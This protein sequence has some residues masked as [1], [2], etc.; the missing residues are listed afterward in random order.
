MSE[1][2]KA[3]YQEIAPEQIDDLIDMIDYFAPYMTEDKDMTDLKTVSFRLDEKLIN[4]GQL[5]SEHIVNGMVAITDIAAEGDLGVITEQFSMLRSFDGRQAWLEVI[6]SPK[7]KLRDEDT[8]SAA[9]TDLREKL[10][11]AEDETEKSLIQES[12]G[13][14]KHDNDQ[15]AEMF[16]L[17]GHGF[18]QDKFN[19]VMEI[20]GQIDPDLHRVDVL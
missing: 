17:P 13:V 20:L 7:R 6:M 14:I 11:L 16:G 2:P 19:E 3:S 1:I 4:V 5:R 9:L 15:L 10:A 12:I 8:W 18:T